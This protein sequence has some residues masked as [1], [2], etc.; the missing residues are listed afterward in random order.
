MVK[1]NVGDKIIFRMSI[2][3]AYHQNLIP[4]SVLTQEDIKLLERGYHNEHGH[5][6]LKFYGKVIEIAERKDIDKPYRLVYFLLSNGTKSGVLE[7][8]K[9][10][11]KASLLEKLVKKFSPE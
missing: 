1:Y 6:C 9:N 5:S 10:L 4:Q 7:T 2:L 3:E 11:R 8:H